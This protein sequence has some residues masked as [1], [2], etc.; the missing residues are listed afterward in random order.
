MYHKKKGTH[1]KHSN[2]CKISS[3]GSTIARQGKQFTSLSSR[4]RSLAPAAHPA[5]RI[6]LVTRR[7][8]SLKER[9]QI[10]FKGVVLAGGRPVTVKRTTG[11]MVLPP[12]GS[13]H[14]DKSQLTRKQNKSY[15]C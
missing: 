2:I 13:S 10:S 6:N 12:K 1:I 9:W 3:Y 7:W 8:Q 5:S 14:L 15:Q 4:D 11:Q